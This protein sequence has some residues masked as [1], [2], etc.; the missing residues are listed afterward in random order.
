MTKVFFSVT[1]SVDG[2]IAP[3]MMKMGVPLEQWL[4]QWMELQKYV[5]EQRFFR[6]NLNLGGGGETGEDNRILEETFNR[7]GASIM[8]KRMFD[9]GEH[10][11]PEEAPF[12][13]PVFVLT[14]EVRKPWERPGGTTFHFVNDGIQSALQQARGVAGDRDIRIAGG[15]NVILQYLNSGLVDEFAVALSPVLLGAGLR[16]FEGIDPSKIA[17][18]IVKAVNSPMVTHLNY[19]VRLR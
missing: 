2:F 16:L 7:T 6:E 10:A 8:G 18:D 3:E 14:K 12:H 4:P 17:L 13:T 15:A 9:G 11:W 19:A 5:F 1:M